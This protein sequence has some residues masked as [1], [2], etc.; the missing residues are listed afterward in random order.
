MRAAIIIAL[1]GIF[2]ATPLDPQPCFGSKSEQCEHAP[3]CGR[4]IMLQQR[5]AWE[6]RACA[7]GTAGTAAG[8]CVEDPVIDLWRDAAFMEFL[9]SCEDVAIRRCE[10]AGT[11]C[12]YPAHPGAHP[13][14]KVW[15][16]GTTP[17]PTTGGQAPPKAPPADVPARAPP[18]GA[19]LAF[20]A[21]GQ[22]GRPVCRSWGVEGCTP[23]FKCGERSNVFI[24]DGPDCV[25]QRESKPVRRF[26]CDAQGCVVQ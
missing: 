6:M 15:A 9:G 1:L 19:G 25:I 22:L 23:V 18:S 14:C 8:M 21:D 5:P 17:A 12:D 7:K 10:A 3:L 2:L 16:S 20:R 13:R 24:P 4:Y 11:C 26:F